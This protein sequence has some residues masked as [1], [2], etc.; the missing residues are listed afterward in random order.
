MKKIL[1]T[2]AIALL[3][4]CATPPGPNL[5]DAYNQDLEVLGEDL[6]KGTMSELEVAHKAAALARHYFPTDYKL[7]SVR[8]YK[9]LL[10]NR[11]ARGEIHKDEYDYLWSEKINSLLAD[12]Q[13]QRADNLAQQEAQQN[14]ALAIG[15]GSM[16]RS[17]MTNAPPAPVHCRSTAYGGVVSTTCN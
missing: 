16:S 12:R 8:D 7:H 3:S 9:I 1:I 17:M 13:Q 10:A 5:T 15:F 4:G 6:G 2:I 14:R 11:L